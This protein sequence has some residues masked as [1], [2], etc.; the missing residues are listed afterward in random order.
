[1]ERERNIMLKQVLQHQFESAIIIS[2]FNE[3]YLNYWEIETNP[4]PPDF[5][6]NTLELKLERRI[7]R[8]AK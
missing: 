4:F 7:K 3:L 8:K 6:A 2:S 5:S 1:M